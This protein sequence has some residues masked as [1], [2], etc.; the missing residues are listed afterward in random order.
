MGYP[1]PRSRWRSIPIPGE[2][3][4][5]PIPGQDGGG[6]ITHLRSG[7]GGYPISCQYGGGTPL[8]KA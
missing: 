4:A 7:Q 3:G 8:G 6:G 2:D 5:P 1:N